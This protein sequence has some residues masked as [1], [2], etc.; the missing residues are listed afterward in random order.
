MKPQ[1]LDL[2]LTELRISPTE[3]T[4]SKLLVSIL[5]GLSLETLHEVIISNSE[6]ITSLWLQI[7][8]TDQHVCYFYF[9]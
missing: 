3:R 7:T 9:E 5:A 6:K 4:F 8:V 1:Y 2:A